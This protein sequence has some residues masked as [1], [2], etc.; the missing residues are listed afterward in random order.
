MTTKLIRI[1]NSKGIRIPKPLIEQSKLTDEVELI[2]GDNEIIL[3]SASNP[4][5]GWEKAFRDMAKNQDDELIDVNSPTLD[6]QFDE[7]EWTW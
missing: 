4:R 5:Q 7:S 3:R 2:V 6:N 1:G